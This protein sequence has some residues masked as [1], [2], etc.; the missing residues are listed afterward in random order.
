ME[1]LAITPIHAKSNAVKQAHMRTLALSYNYNNEVLRNTDPKTCYTTMHKISGTVAQNLRIGSYE[2]NQICPTLLTVEGSKQ[3]TRLHKGD[4]S[5]SLQASRKLPKALL[6]E[7]S[8][9]EKSS[10]TTLTSI[11][12][13]YRRQ[14]EKISRLLNGMVQ[15]LERFLEQSSQSGEQSSNRAPRPEDPQERFML[16]RPHEFKGSTNPMEAKSW[17][18]S[19]EDI[20]E[21]LRMPELERA[22][23]AV[24]ML[25]G[26][27][28][29]CWEGAK[30][31]RRG[32]KRWCIC[33]GS[34]NAKLLEFEAFELSLCERSAASVQRYRR[35]G[36]YRI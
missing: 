15:L 30:L 22:I 14:S 20:F 19:L 27:A 6:N 5:Q 33:A 29:I 34:G 7:A 2:L 3:S 16:Q 26:D 11:R 9:Q 25:R 13:V 28:R 32:L 8:Q 23:C 10:A 12:A 18:M 17:I 1:Q 24:F 4:V 35:S 31:T 21:Y 36:D